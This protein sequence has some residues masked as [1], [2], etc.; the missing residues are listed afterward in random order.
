M[1]KTYGEITFLKDF[2]FTAN[3]SFDQLFYYNSYFNNKLVG[4][5][6]PGG[7]AYK[8]FTRRNSA[9]FNQLLNYIKSFGNHNLNI[10][11]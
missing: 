10:L 7:R 3:L 1:A 9:N 5:G 8:T 11:L 6:A 2:K 4:D